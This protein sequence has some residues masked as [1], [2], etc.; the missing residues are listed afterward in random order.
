[1]TPDVNYEVNANNVGLAF[2]SLFTQNTS[3]SSKLNTKKDFRNISAW[4]TKDW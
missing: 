2:F 1:M 3:E 4:M